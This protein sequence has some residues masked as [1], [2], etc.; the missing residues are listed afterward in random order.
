MM[1]MIKFSKIFD[2]NNA[3]EKNALN[4]NQKTLGRLY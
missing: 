1:E 2:Q 4:N 3:E